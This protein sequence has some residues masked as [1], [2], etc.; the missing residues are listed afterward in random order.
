MGL[1]QRCGQT[2]EHETEL[3]ALQEQYVGRLSEPTVNRFLKEREI[4]FFNNKLQKKKK[5]IKSIEV[6]SW[7][8]QPWH[9]LAA[10]FAQIRK[11][12]LRLKTGL[13]V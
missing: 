9:D 5:A 10:F 6:E 8:A 12:K 2:L 7:S 3:G 1:N 13:K 11:M 4:F